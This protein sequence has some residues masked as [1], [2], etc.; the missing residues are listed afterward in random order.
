VTRTHKALNLAGVLLPFVGLVAAVVVLWGT[1][2][3]GWTDLAILAGMYTVTCL[4]VT[5]GFHR[6]FTHRS[7]ATYRPVQ[8]ALAI[9][10]SMAVEDPVM[11][12]STASSRSG[13]RSAWR[14]R[15]ASAT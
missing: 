4:G 7:Y 1:E 12:R 11:R 15:S 5:L 9:I 3:V 14:S 13:W 2:L 10:G 6:L 8:Y